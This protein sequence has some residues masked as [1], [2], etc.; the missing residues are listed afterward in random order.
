MIWCRLW[1]RNPGLLLERPSL[2]LRFFLACVAARGA[3]GECVARCAVASA[4]ALVGILCAT[5]W[6]SASRAAGSGNNFGADDGAQPGGRSSTW[7]AVQIWFS[8]A[9]P[10]S[11]SSS[12]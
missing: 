6:G 9:L 5:P 10:L 4:Q 3:F 7:P 8:A 11:T 12:A 2:V 1:A